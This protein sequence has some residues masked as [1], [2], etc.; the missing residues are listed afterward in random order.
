MSPG[1]CYDVAA[2]YDGTTVR[3][4]IDGDLDDHQPV[5]NPALVFGSNTENLTIGVDLPGGD[6]YFDGE[7]SN[8]RIYN[9]A[10]STSEIGAM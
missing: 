6:E 10:L 9:R 5:P 2:T 7:I 3:F 4:Y 8:V 1:Q